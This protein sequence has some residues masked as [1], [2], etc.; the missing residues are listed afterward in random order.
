M[1]PL[2]ES[3]MAWYAAAF[4]FGGQRLRHMEPSDFIAAQTMSPSAFC[5]VGIVYLATNLDA[6]FNFQHLKLVQV[7]S[8][9]FGLI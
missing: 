6:D 4:T 8:N 1:N 3:K 5:T 7:K 9:R 2:A